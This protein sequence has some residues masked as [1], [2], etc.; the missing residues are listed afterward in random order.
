MSLIVDPAKKIVILKDLGKVK[1]KS[2]IDL[3]ES[4]ERQKPEIGVVYA[5]GE[6]K[7]PMDFEKGDRV[8]YRKYMDNRVDIEG[9]RF[10]FIDFKDILA[11][12]REDELLN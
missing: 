8:V 7:K 1:T 11:V 9:E 4:T 3:P 2:G 10:N 6:G 12:I 5:F